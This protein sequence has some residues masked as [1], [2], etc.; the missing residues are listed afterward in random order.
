LL[1]DLEPVVAQAYERSLLHLKAFGA[2]LSDHQIDDL[3]TRMREATEHGSIP[4]FEGAASHADW[5][6]TEAA[7]AVDPNVTIPFTRR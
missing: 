4:S 6:A 1:E 2:R 5:L 7:A 3:V